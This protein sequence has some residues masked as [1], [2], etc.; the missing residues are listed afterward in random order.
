MLKRT[1]ENFR[2]Y[3]NYRRIASGEPA[4]AGAGLTTLYI[5]LARSA[6]RRAYIEGHLRALGLQPLRIDAVDGR[7][8]SYEEVSSRGWYDDAV[9]TETFSRSLIL[10][11]IGCALSHVR[12]YEY[13]RDHSIDKALIVED[14]AQLDPRTVEQL[15]AAMS[16]LPQDW[17]LLQLR[18]D[19]Q[20]YEIVGAR[21]VYFPAR[22][23]LPVAAT[24]YVIRGKAVET[25][26]KQVYPLRYPAD[27][28]LGRVSWWGL[29]V[30]GTRPKLAGVNNIF[31]SA[32]QGRKNLKFV[33]S[34]AVKTLILRVIG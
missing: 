21:S 8:L 33:L 25:L 15:Q 6:E 11:E 16:E 3:F 34:N 28:F 32:I 10:P 12:A 20:D 31:P 13:V 23:R 29:K 24:A 4:P 14:D 2:S 18:Y 19:I 26:L 5:N 30:Y 1:L 17:D 7:A 27:S 9:A 22:E